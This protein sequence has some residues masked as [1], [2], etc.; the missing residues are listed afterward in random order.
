MCVSRRLCVVCAVLEVCLTAVEGCVGS[1]A[2]APGEPCADPGLLGSRVTEG[3]P[4]DPCAFSGIGGVTRTKFY[5][6]E[7]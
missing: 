3:V 1:R 4:G 5:S 7:P 2:R 6:G